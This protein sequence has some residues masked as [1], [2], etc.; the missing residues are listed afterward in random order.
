MSI[1]DITTQTL[2][3]LLTLIALP[4]CKIYQ[5]I[6]D[7]FS[8]LWVLIK[9]FNSC[10]RER[11]MNNNMVSKNWAGISTA[12]IHYVKQWAELGWILDKIK[13]MRLQFAG[14][15]C[16][17]KD[18]SVSRLLLW[19]PKHGKRKNGRPSF[20]WAKLLKQNTGLQEPDIKTAMLGR[21]VW[22]AI[23]IWDVS[24]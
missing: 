15:C 7:G 5:F 21:S 2:F 14:H 16:R 3:T 1:V 22:R 20:T 11:S 9:T 13:N 19:K 24:T 8:F 23:T 6:V 18:E 4:I 12:N 10:Q 17:S